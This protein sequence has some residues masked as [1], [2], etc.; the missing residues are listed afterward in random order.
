MRVLAILGLSAVLLVVCAVVLGLTAWLLRDLSIAITG[1][2]F[3]AW[4]AFG[5][6]VLL[7]AVF[8]TPGAVR[9]VREEIEIRRNREP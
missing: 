9:V 6:A 3:S 1:H 7:W 2:A 8:L 5:L 4:E